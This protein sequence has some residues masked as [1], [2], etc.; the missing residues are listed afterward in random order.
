VASPESARAAREDEVCQG[1][2]FHQ[3][4]LARESTAVF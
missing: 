3:H 2:G 4:H 1:S